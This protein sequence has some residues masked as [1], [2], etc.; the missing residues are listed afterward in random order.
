MAIANL[1]NVN[2]HYLQLQPEV[3][4]ENQLENIVLVHGLAANLGFWYFNIA[5][6]LAEKFRVTM[7]DLRGHGRSSMP[8]SGYTPAELAE[9]MAQLLDHL[10]I[11]RFHLLGHSLGGSVVAHYAC[12]YPHRL[13]SL[14]F[15]D[16]R[17]K[18]FQLAMTL[19]DW[20]QWR[21]YQTQLKDL[22]IDL[23]S[24]SGELGYQLLAKMARFHIQ[25]PELSAKL[26]TILPNSL[27]AGFAFTG[28]GG[29]RSAKSLLYL[30][31]TTTAIHDLSQNDC[32]S[33]EQLRSIDCPILAVYGEQSQTLLTLKG[34]QSVWPHLT[35]NIVPNA[36]H[37]FP[38]TQPEALIRPVKEFLGQIANLQD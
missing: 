14:I 35:V 20:P 21:E 5:P 2:L 27:F 29:D 3:T 15:A 7:F 18:L 36:G 10:E 13:A 23:S 32:I 24:N 17:L 8:P 19:S 25:S 4:D 37:F 9:D 33:I 22:G 6:A 26:Q 38:T 16:T 11:E 30:L 12:R 1:S 34:L 31:E 28:K